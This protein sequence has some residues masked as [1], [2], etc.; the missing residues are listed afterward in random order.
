VAPTFPAPT[1]VIFIW[2][3]LSW[4]EIGREVINRWL[5]KKNN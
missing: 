5:N 1:T 4:C 3:V 2:G